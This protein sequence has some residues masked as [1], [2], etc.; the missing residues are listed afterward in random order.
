MAFFRGLPIPPWRPPHLNMS[1]TPTVKHTHGT[2]KKTRQNSKRTQEIEKA[3]TCDSTSRHQQYLMTQYG[4]PFLPFAPLHG[5]GVGN[6]NKQTDTHT[7]RFLHNN[8]A[9]FKTITFLF[10]YCF[11]RNWFKTDSKWDQQSISLRHISRKPTDRKLSGGTDAKKTVQ[12]R[13]NLY[14]NLTDMIYKLN[15]QGSFVSVA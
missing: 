12:S 7:R 2:W 5:K 9:L 3:T 13:P 8:N 6:K 11:K 10:L 4:A 15:Q 1:G 14:G